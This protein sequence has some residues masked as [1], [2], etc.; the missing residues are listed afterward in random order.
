MVEEK[1]VK[2]TTKYYGRIYLRSG[3][4]VSKQGL[5]VK[6]YADWKVGE[7]DKRSY[8]ERRKARVRKRI[9]PSYGNEEGE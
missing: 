5:K 6:D 4:G 3:V 8:E 1:E 2:K 7:E 9:N